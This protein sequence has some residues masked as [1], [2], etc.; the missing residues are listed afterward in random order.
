MLIY[1]SVYENIWRIR[2]LNREWMNEWATYHIRSWKIMVPKKKRPKTSRWCWWGLQDIG[3]VCS[4]GFFPME[5]DAS[6]RLVSLGSPRTVRAEHLGRLVIWSSVIWLAI[7]SLATQIPKTG[8]K[9]EHTSWYIYI[10]I[11]LF[12]LFYTILYLFPALKKKPEKRHRN[13]T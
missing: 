1:H 10:Y 5:K 6:P 4:V 2:Y 13:P 7:I 8:L 11:Y 12:I 3:Y 9:T